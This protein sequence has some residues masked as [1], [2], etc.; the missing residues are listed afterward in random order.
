MTQ[1]ELALIKYRMERGREAIE[2]AKLLFGSVTIC[3]EFL[4]LVI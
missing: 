3:F 1:E 2:E 4:F